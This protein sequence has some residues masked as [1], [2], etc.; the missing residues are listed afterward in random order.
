MLYKHLLDDYDTSDIAIAISESIHN[1]LRRDILHE[2]LVNNRTYEVVG[3]QMLRSPRH[4]GRIMKEE[5]PKVK[6]WLVR[7]MS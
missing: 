4:I 1:S 3:E 7:E 5:T 6:E 2:C